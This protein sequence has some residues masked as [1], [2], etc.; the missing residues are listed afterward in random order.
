MYG[1]TIGQVRSTVVSVRRWA[2]GVA[3]VAQLIHNAPFQA[4][5]AAEPKRSRDI[6]DR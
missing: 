4:T 2:T 6:A 5:C 3:D 1:G